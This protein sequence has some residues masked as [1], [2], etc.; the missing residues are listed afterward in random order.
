MRSEETSPKRYQNVI[1]MAW[2]G[3]GGAE[4]DLPTNGEV[5]IARVG[6][7]A[8]SKKFAVVASGPVVLQ[9]AVGPL[10]DWRLLAATS[11]Q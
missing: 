6:G 3:V 5:G 1:P 11:R 10:S 9:M 7:E 8:I 4:H 2:H